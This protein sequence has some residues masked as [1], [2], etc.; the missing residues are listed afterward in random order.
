MKS[1]AKNINQPARD[2][3]PPQVNYAPAPVIFFLLL[4]AG[5]FA[6]GL[7]VDHYSGDF[8]QKVYGPY[9]SLE[10]VASHQP[11]GGDIDP[12]FA[13]GKQLF[14]TACAPCHQPTGQ[15][16]AGQYPPLAGSEWVLPASPERTI[17]IVLNGLAGPIQIKGAE[18][19]NPAASMPPWGGVYSDADIAAILTF[20]RGN[21]DWGNKAAAVKPE[22]VK[23]VRSAVG[24]R[25]TPWTSEELQAVPDK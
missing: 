15:G 10:D 18:F 25:S 22:D 11:K 5:L 9:N 7:F 1:D 23:K 2:D 16:I 6:T 14:M 20:V 4:A 8:N 3:A 12:S 21:K 17:R 24:D 13:K 19:N